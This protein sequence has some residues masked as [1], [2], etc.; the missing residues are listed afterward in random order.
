MLLN[1]P[2]KL[3]VRQMQYCDEVKAILLEG[4]PF[5]LRSF[6]N[7]KT[8][9]QAMFALNLSVRTAEHSAALHSKS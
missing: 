5:T 7:L 3:N 1:S 9:I 6:Q 8:S 4:R 2:K